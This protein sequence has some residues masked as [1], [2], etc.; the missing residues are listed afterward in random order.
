[1]KLYTSEDIYKALKN[2]VGDNEDFMMHLSFKSIGKTENGFDDLFNAIKKRDGGTSL[3]A[4]FS[5]ENVSES[6]PYFDLENTPVCVGAF[7]E[8]FRKCEGV[9]RSIHPTHSVTAFGENAKYYVSNHEEDITPCSKNSPLMKL[10]EKGG[11]ILM[12]GCGLRPNT[13][14]H[15]IEELVGTPY[16]LENEK[17]MYTLKTK[18]RE[19]TKG[20]YNH[21]FTYDGGKHYIQRYDR[22]SEIMNI[23]T[24]EFLDTFVNIIPADEL[25]EKAVKVLKENPMF[26]VDKD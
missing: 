16:V 20:Y 3:Y 9:L 13:T 2:C 8:Y 11:K 5:F 22:V 18:D 10:T 24:K 15:G 14:M 12:L 21:C 19:W 7:P 25:R 17:V 26:F 4:G 23:E 6:N 1:M